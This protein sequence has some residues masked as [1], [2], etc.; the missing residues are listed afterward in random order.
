[1]RSLLDMLFR[2]S[3][4]RTGMLC[5]WMLGWW[6]AVAWG[7]EARPIVGP[8]ASKEDVIDAYGWPTGQTQAGEK[9]IL[10]YPQGRVVL[11]KGK[12]EAVDFSLN[13]PWPPPRRRPG[14]ATGA[15][16]SWNTN[17]AETLKEAQRRNT[18]ILALFVG[19]DWSPPSHQFL[20]EVSE[21]PEFLTAFWATFVLVKLDYPTRTTQ[22]RTLREQNTALRERYEVT[23]YP[24]LLILEPDGKLAARVDLNKL[25]PGDSY[26]A[27]VVTAVREAREALTP[28]G[29]TA[30]KQATPAAV[31]PGVPEKV[32]E[33]ESITLWSAG[34]A[35]T[36]GLGG[37]AV[38]AA[39]LVWLF[40]RY[41]P[42]VSGGQSTAAERVAEAASGLPSPVEMAEWPL[43]K[44]LAVAWG[45][46]EVNGYQVAQRAGGTDGDLALTR[47]GEAKPSVIVMC[48]P[49]SAGLV[50]AKRLRELFGTITL[51]EVG[52][53]WVIAIAGFS[54]EARQYGR[55][56]RL[57]LIG[58]DT[59]REQLRA[60]IEQDL[61]RVLARR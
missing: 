1:M 41:R 14:T 20:A 23:T 46:A 6:G 47:A 48:V 35:L 16:D 4:G 32:V 7:A 45:L 58:R 43:E 17:W 55:E 60:L 18:R 21:S 44:L 5:V 51:E 8:G 61:A 57:V 54:S 52:T 10:T 31:V 33:L 13:V 40:W 22:V 12:V 3:L 24:A 49:A 30:A 15:G 11:E 2:Y 34:R 26:R 19:S 27:Q 56:Q 28:G 53:A 25:K 36:W 37:G 38:L 50:S 59:L 42:R 39:A 29:G 9:E